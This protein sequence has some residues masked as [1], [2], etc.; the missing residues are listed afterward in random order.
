MDTLFGMPG[1][2]ISIVI[3]KDYICHFHDFFLKK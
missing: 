3:G 2:G 1:E